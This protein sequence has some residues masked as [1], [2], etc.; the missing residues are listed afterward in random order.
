LVHPSRI[1]SEL[2]SSLCTTS[3]LFII[4]G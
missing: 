2:H 3:D 4:S 1:P